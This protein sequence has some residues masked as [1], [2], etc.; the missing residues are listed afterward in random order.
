MNSY[1]TEVLIDHNLHPL[2]RGKMA[3]ADLAAT[4]TNSSCGDKLKI[5]LKIKNRKIVDSD[6]NISFS[7]V[8]DLRP[9][10]KRLEIGSTLSISELLGIVKLLG[11]VA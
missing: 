9:S 3:D 11:G 5:H 1:Y 6:S 4:L 8:T 10:I 7:G 2:H